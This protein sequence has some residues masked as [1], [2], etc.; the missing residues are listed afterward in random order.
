M[1]ISLIKFI[2]KRSSFIISQFPAIKNII[3]YYTVIIIIIAISK[4]QNV[5]ANNATGR[6]NVKS[7]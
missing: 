6:S 7:Y 3:N 4:L 5:M 1:S 2:L